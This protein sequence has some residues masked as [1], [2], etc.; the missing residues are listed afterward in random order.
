MKV[1]LFLDFDG[2]LTPIVST[3]RK[4]ILSAKAKN[5]LRRL[6]K[7]RAFKVSIISGRAIKDLR[8][9]IGIKNIVYAGNHGMEI[10]GPGISYKAVIKR[11]VASAMK[12]CNDLLNNRLHSIPGIKVENKGMTVSVHFRNVAQSMVPFISKTV[13]NV[14]RENAKN[15]LIR[16]D[17]GKKVLELKPN[18]A[19]DKGKAAQLILSRYKKSEGTVAVVPVFIGDDSTDE[20]AF[21]AFRNNGITV[22]VGKPR[23]TFA[24]YRLRN[25]GE[26]IKFLE[27]IMETE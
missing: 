11:G 22:L 25:P 23:N 4:A 21:K 20:D 5:V 16:I 18:I 2:T 8:K 14:A 9:K 26:V 17:T 19:W 12:R 13:R 15:G 1:Y 10:K 6:A 7:H 27:S 3:P 24:K